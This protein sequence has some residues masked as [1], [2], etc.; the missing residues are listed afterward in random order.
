VKDQPGVI[1]SISQILGQHGISIASIHQHETQVSDS[2]PIVI[3]THLAVEG[4]MRKALAEIAAL[5]TTAK[6]PVS[7]RIMD[8]PKEFA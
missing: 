5:P 2:V 7:L 6:P 3:T 4:P 1:G 8:Q